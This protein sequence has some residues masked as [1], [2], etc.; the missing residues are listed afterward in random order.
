M[1]Q[2]SALD[3]TVPDAATRWR[4]LVDPR[5]AATGSDASVNLTLRA[6]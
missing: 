1:D 4:I 5:R 6:P 3:F 2:V